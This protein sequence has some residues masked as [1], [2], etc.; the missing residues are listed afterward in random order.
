MQPI[1]RF[2]NSFPANGYL[3]STFSEPGPDVNL[4]SIVYQVGGIGVD[5]DILLRELKKEGNF[6]WTDIT[7]I[8]SEGLDDLLYLLTGVSFMTRYGSWTAW[9]I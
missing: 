2:I 9:I 5:E 1:E 7:Y 3:S 6:P 4:G 8:D